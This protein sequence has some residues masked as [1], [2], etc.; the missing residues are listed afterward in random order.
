MEATAKSILITGCSS[1]IGADAAHGL[2]E[3]G[4]RVFASCRKQADCD[5]LIAQGFDSPR[6]DYTD[7]DTI[8]SGLAEV[9][10]VRAIANNRG[11][12]GLRDDLDVGGL[13]L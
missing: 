12:P 9:L 4:W 2:R 7:S 5:A 6:I 11:V 3:R 13:Y 8:T 10:A 1:G